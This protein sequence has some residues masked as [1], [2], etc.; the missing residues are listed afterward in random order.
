[1]TATVADADT[2]LP[3][4]PGYRLVEKLGEGGMGEVYRA[5]DVSDHRDVA[6]KLLRP[7]QTLRALEHESQVMG[8]L[9]HP[10]VVG[11]HGWGETGGRHWLAM[12]YVRGT[13]LRGK[14]SAGQPWPAA[15]ALDVITAVGC[16]LTHI[17]GRGVLHLDLKPENVL[18]GDG[19]E[20]KVSDFGLAQPRAGSGDPAALAGTQGTLDYCAPEQR[21]GLP[22]DVRTDLFALATIAYE[23][24]TGRLPGRVYVSA[25]E[26][27]VALPAAVDLVLCRA[28]A[29]DRDERH[30][31]VTEFA[32]LLT[33]AMNSSRPAPRVA[34]GT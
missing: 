12:E 23:L 31:S 2:Y 4:V 6:L 27:N 29:R 26:R 13:T 20:I 15:A 5:Q 11:I 19:G 32:A 8:R 16:A 14:L 21:F 18:C 10:H 24:F 9:V 28:L 22:V 30:A 7:G 1:M 34:E 3:V 33:E 17:H 25:A